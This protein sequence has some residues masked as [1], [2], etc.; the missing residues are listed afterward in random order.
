MISWGKAGNI[1]ENRG[2]MREKKLRRGASLRG[3]G[4]P[5]LF[6]HASAVSE[7]ENCGGLEKPQNFLAQG[8]KYNFFHSGFVSTNPETL[9]RKPVY[10]RVVSTNPQTRLTVFFA[11]Q[12]IVALDGGNHSDRRFIAGLRA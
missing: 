5:A 12:K 11:A 4:T 1:G 7:Q 10:L 3:Q 9:Q 2:K 8:C 6:L